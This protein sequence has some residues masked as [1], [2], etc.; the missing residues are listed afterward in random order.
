MF[1]IPYVVYKAGLLVGFLYIL[2]LGLINVLVNL[3]YG[4][5]ILRTPGDH[6]FTGYAQRYLPGWGKKIALLGVLISAYGVCLAYLVK[7]GEFLYLVLGVLS[8]EFFTFLVFIFTSLCVYLGIKAVSEAE[9]LIVG[10]LV[11]LSFLIPVLGIYKINFSTAELVNLSAI[12]LPYGVIFG[13]FGALSVIPELEEILRDEP[14]KLKKAIVI[15]SLIPVFVYLVFA[16][17]VVGISGPSVSDDAITGLRAFLSWKVVLLGAILGV[18]AMGSSYLA[19]GYALREVWFRDYG[20]SKWQAVMLALVPP[21][22]LFFLGAR[23]FIQ[24]LDVGGAISGGITGFILLLVFERAKNLSSKE[25]AFSL[26]VPRYV[27]SFLY[28]LFLLGMLFPFI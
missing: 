22:V 10:G 24:I 9:L 14:E 27:L 1:G 2:G 23:N 5:I 18:L 28:L 21:L 3:I 11:F 8:P 7:I 26:R 15:G 17:G 13:A 16:F 6:Q 4:E 25:P 12:F 20:F 19:V